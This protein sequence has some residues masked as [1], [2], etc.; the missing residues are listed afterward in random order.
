M[1]VQLKLFADIA[2]AIKPNEEI[3][4]CISYG[5]KPMPLVLTMVLNYAHGLIE[6]TSVGCVVY[7][8]LPHTDD[9]SGGSL[10][11]DTTSLFHMNSVVNKLS[12]MKPDNPIDA[13]KI[14]LGMGVAEG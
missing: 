8:R 2:S 9:V 10:I 11:Y 3:Y 6:N 1:D 4:A 5:T 12:E 13:I 7:G 14:M